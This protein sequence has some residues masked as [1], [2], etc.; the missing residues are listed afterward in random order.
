MPGDVDLR[1]FLSSTGPVIAPS[2]NP[3]GEPPA[4]TAEEAEAYFHDDVDFLVD[5]GRR[6]GAPSTVARIEGGKWKV[7]RE[8]A[9]ILN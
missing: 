6:T 1:E 3:S 9:V 5:A 8:G 4:E 2:A 7:L